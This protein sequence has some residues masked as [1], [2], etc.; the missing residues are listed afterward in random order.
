MCDLLEQAHVE[1]AVLNVLNLVTK[2]LLL[3]LAALLRF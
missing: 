2:H 3:Q 1:A